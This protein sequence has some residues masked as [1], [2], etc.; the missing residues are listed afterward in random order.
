MV[1]YPIRPSTRG[2][3]NNTGI[4]VKYDYLFYRW[5]TR[6]LVLF[7]LRVVGRTA[8]REHE[9]VSDPCLFIVFT[10]VDYRS[11]LT[12][13]VLCRWQDGRVTGGHRAR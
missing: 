6:I 9:A 7:T 2:A 10:A 13:D 8:R 12:A 1:K 4:D 5:Q 11:D 3:F